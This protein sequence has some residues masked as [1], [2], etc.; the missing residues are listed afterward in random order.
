MVR[1]IVAV[2]LDVGRGRLAVEAVD[3]LLAAGERTGARAL[4]GQAAPARGLTLERVYYVNRTTGPDGTASRSG[5]E[6]RT[7]S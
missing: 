4:H 5:S 6:E 3:G 7:G 1:S 2:L